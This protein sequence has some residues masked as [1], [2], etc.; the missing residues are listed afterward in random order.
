MTF[1]SYFKFSSKP[2]SLSSTV[3]GKAVLKQRC[4]ETNPVET[5]LIKKENGLDFCQIS[6]PARLTS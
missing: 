6:S 3:V 5:L 4:E 1:K 2:Q